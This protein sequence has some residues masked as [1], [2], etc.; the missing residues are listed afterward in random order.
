MDI[1]IFGAGI[2]GLM[3][4]IALR[5]RGHRCRIYERSLQAQ[6]AG[7]G[8]IL[9]PDGIAS[10]ERFGVR[11]AGDVSGTPLE[12]YNCRDSAGRIVY[13]QDM[14]AGS[15]GIRRRDL[16]MALIR[17]LGD[18]EGVTLADCEGLEFGED[19]H[20]SAAKLRSHEGIQRVAADLYVAA[21]GV[22][23][24]ARQAI[25]PDWPTTPDP[26]PE[27]VGMVRCQKAVAWA[28]HNLN[29]F[30][31]AEG[32]LALGVLPVDQEQVVWYLQFD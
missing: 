28:S 5:A 10:L 19:F 3:S 25:F 20:V 12:R 24:R 7:M 22:N 2:A 11:L 31:A 18:A 15:R 6:D 29:K 1:A 27:F 21:E 4:A 9:V 13:T 17:A 32:G 23:S 8:F 30:H 26:V 16:T 14:P